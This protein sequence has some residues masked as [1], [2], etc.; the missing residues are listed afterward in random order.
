MVHHVDTSG[1]AKILR[2]YEVMFSLR[3]VFLFTS[4]DTFCGDSIFSSDNGTC[5]LWGIYWNRYTVSGF[6]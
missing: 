3:N 4:L 1:E 5:I 6:V 2:K